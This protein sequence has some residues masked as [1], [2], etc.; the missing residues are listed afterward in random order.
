MTKENLGW[1]PSRVLFGLSRIGYTPHGAIA[2]IV[3]NSVTYGAHNINIIIVQDREDLAITRKNNIREYVIVDDGA[4]MDKD[5]ILQALNLGADI[6]YP[7]K[8]LSKFGLGLKSASFSQGKR[9]EIISSKGSGQEFSKYYVDLNEITTEYFCNNTDI[10][11]EDQK[12]IGNFLPDKKGTIIRITDIHK[13]N[14]PSLK[15]TID[16]LTYR[17]GTIYYYYI[18]DGLNLSL[19]GE[20][21]EKVDVLF[22]EEAEVN[23]NL[24]E[25]E[26][27]GRTVTWIK[28]LTTQTL[29]IE[30]DPPI[31]AEIEVTQLPHPPIHALDGEGEQARVRNKYKIEAGNYGYYVYRNKRLISWAERFDGI[32]PQDQ[33]FYSFR[34]RILLDDKADDAFNIDV[35]KTHLTLSDDAHNALNDLS[36]E[37]KRKSKKAWE[38]AK[39]LKDQVLGEEPNSVSND[40]ADKLELPDTML[41]DEIPSPEE[42][43]RIKQKEIEVKE[44][45]KNKIKEEVAREKQIEG[46]HTPVTDD[47]IKNYITG[48]AAGN[49]RIFRVD[50]IEDNLLWEPYWEDDWGVCVRINR[51]HRFARC[52]FE[53]NAGNLDLQVIFE[54][55][56]LQA[57]QAEIAMR[58]SAIQKDDDVESVIFEYRENMSSLLVKMMRNA[59]V[60]M[61]PLQ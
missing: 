17:L 21:I 24:N 4:G 3:D 41:G 28:K 25:H 12:L 49:K 31:S 14:H 23:G 26:W 7:E 48:G 45:I 42:T 2:D 29:D 37:Y 58:R 44:K 27:N 51:N 53:D 35:K 16:Q 10:S 39:K 13:N 8:S 30:S 43:K 36:D 22:T 40:I 54:I 57:S 47:D 60:K 32:I 20:K 11:E 61:P 1:N 9:L 38:R 6:V 55:L 52:I 33:D 18:K 19:N 50:H 15:A 56:L 34:G 5:G 59:D 46:D